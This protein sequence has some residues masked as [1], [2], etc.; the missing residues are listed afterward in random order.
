M[1]D[2][3]WIQSC[4]QSVWCP[5]LL[6]P[7]AI[8]ILGLWACEPTNRKWMLA[9]A[10]APAIALYLGSKYELMSAVT[11]PWAIAVLGPAGIAMGE[12]WAWLRRRLFFW[13]FAL[14]LGFLSIFA[15]TSALLGEAY[16]NP[17]DQYCIGGPS[18]DCRF[19][20]GL[21]ADVFFGYWAFG[22]VLVG[23]YVAGIGLI[24][25][26]VVRRRRG[27]SGAHAAPG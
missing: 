18:P 4:F 5:A 20:Y 11:V 17:N 13:L 14:L 25:A 26:G 7:W 1:S 2:I 8:P 10:P 23:G 6:T 22:V 15:A 27:R 24:A 12:H 16:T 19:D 21:L 9:L 3:A